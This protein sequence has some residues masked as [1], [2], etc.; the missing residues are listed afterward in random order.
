MITEEKREE[1]IKDLE[2]RTGIKITK[3]EQEGITNE[4]IE[5]KTSQQKSKGSQ[6]AIGPIQ[7]TTGTI[8]NITGT[9]NYKWVLWLGDMGG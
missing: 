3:I 6:N 4:K 7:N 5:P 9:K 1:L 8:Q 2:L